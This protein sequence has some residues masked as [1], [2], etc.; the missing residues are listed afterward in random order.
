[1]F[2]EQFSILF[3]TVETIQSKLDTTDSKERMLFR[4]KLS[5]I[6][7]LGV[8]WLDQWMTL[9]EKLTDAM[10]KLGEL[11]TGNSRTNFDQTVQVRYAPEPNHVQLESMIFDMT[12][13]TEVALRRGMAYFDLLMFEEASKALEHAVPTINEPAAYLFLAASYTALGRLSEGRAQLEAVKAYLKNPTLACA[14]SEIEAVI[15]LREGDKEGAVRAYLDALCAMPNYTDVWFN[16]G[17]CYLAISEPAAAERMLA[18]V[19]KR[20]PLDREAHLLRIYSFLE[21]SSYEEALTECEDAYKKFPDY[22]ELM[23]V[24]SYVCQMTGNLELGERISR[25]MLSTESMRAEGYL[26]ASWY[27]LN[28]GQYTKSQ[29]ILN[30]LLCMH[31]NH[32]AGLLQ[33]AISESMNPNKTRILKLLSVSIDEP[34]KDLQ[35]IISGLMHADLSRMKAACKSENLPIRKLAA[36][37]CG[38]TLMQSGQYTDAMEHL[39]LANA[40]GTKNFAILTA[41]HVTALKL[42]RIDEARIFL[43]QACLA[44]KQYLLKCH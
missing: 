32:P 27:A 40:I 41:L 38:T 42:G 7:E 44:E 23:A 10:D 4:E 11:K 1:M 20:D 35:N 19:L 18:H 12:N 30:K 34:Y 22:F 33:L 36:Y 9:E 31:R 25:Y 37:I 21:R 24:Y 3:Q 43:D 39:L 16:L 15:C 6:H 8:S 26:H 5:E 29:L 14:A 2:E 13:Q 28:S 17:A